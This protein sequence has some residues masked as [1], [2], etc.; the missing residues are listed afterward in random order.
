MREIL[1][2]CTD[3]AY[4]MDATRGAL[5]SPIVYV[6]RSIASDQLCPDVEAEIDGFELI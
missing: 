4:G 3:T 1:G 6:K 2:L 5:D